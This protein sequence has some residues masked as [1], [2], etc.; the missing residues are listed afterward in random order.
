MTNM[1]LLV[2]CH[3]PLLH[4]DREENVEIDGDLHLLHPLGIVALPTASVTLRAGGDVMITF[5]QANERFAYFSDTGEVIDRKTGDA[6][7]RVEVNH[8][9]SY[10][11]IYAFGKTLRGHQVAWLLFY[12]CW[13][14]GEID[15][16][17]GDGLNNRISNLRDGT[18][19]QNQRNQRPGKRNRSGFVGVSW[20]ESSNK[21]MAQ[22]RVDGK[23]AFQGRFRRLKDAVHARRAAAEAN[24]FRR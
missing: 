15:H 20:D 16:D 23:I 17:D 13:P 10:Q 5:E 12:R 1:H 11:K 24:G 6:A 7:G 21:W 18:R 19:S 14:S 8:T 22:I 2:K 9:T 3:L 4:P